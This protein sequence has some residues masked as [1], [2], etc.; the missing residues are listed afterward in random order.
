MNEWINHLK[1]EKETLTKT[2]RDSFPQTNTYISYNLIPKVTTWHHGSKGH[3]ELL[4]A[5]RMSHKA[6]Q[7]AGTIVF[8]YFIWMQSCH[9]SQAKIV[10]VFG[11]LQY[12]L[13]M[14]QVFLSELLF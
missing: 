5:M 8:A 7:Q 4:Y 1:R 10:G 13:L 9:L 6:A 11:H 2:Y 3:L 12:Q 14:F